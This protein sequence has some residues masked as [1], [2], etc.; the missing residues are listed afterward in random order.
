MKTITNT[1]STKLGT[2]S[3]IISLIFS[4]AVSPALA[5]YTTEWVVN[6]P[7]AKAP[8]KTSARAKDAAMN[9]FPNMVVTPWSILF[10]SLSL[11][12]REVICCFSDCVW[13]K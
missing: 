5:L 12:E 4:V 10:L 9:L 11:V 1:R 7:T 8:Q 3:S 13:M 6:A 2:R